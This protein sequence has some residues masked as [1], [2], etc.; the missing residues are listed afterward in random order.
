MRA[1]R[2]TSSST[3][4]ARTS[5]L[6]LFCALGALV[7]APGPA[8]AAPPSPKPA[9]KTGSV[10]S[11]GATVVARLDATARRLRVR[12]CAAQPCE[13]TGDGTAIEF[14][15]PIDLDHSSIDAVEL[16]NGRKVLRVVAR[17]SSREGIAWEA[18]VGAQGT[19]AKVLWSSVTGFANEG[20]GARVL[21]EGKELY[22][23]RLRRELTICGQKETLL[24]PK[25]L[26]PA[27]LE[28]HRV[29]MHRLPQAVRNAAPSLLA[30]ESIEAPFAN[31]AT[32]RGA[33][34]HDGAAPLLVDDDTATAWTETLKG[35]GKGE[36]VVVSTPKST[37]IEKL[38]LVVAPTKKIDGFAQPTSLWLS[39][40]DAT[41]HVAVPPGSSRVDVNLP[42]PISTSCLAL[43]LDRAEQGGA[44]V[45]VGLAELD[46]VPVLPKSIHGLD[47]LVSYLDLDVKQAELAQAILANAGARGA[48]AVE[49]KIATLGDR[50]RLRAI[51]VL[52]AAPC[53]VAGRAIVRLSWDSP[54]QIAKRAREA[55]DGC[56]VGAK[57]AIAE[58]FAKGPDAARE[59]IAE[60]FAKVDPQAALAA[61]L[62]VVRT[63]PATRRRTYRAAMRKVATMT[64]GRDAIAAYLASAATVAPAKNER[65]PV[66]EL[67]RAIA[68][69]PEIAETPGLVAALSKTLLSHAGESASFDARWL[70]AEPVAA[71]ALHGD[72]AA[73]AWLRALSASK[74]RYL[75]ARAISVSGDVD[76]LRPEV[77][78]ALADTEPRVRESAL[79]ALRRGQG[80]TGATPPTIALLELDLWTFVR[81]A[82]AETL[83]ESKGG[84]DVDV[85]LA[86]ATGDDARQVRGAAVR[87]LV[88]RGARSQLKAIR[89]R[90]FDKEESVDV[91]RDAIEGLGHLCDVGSVD[92]LTDI[93]KSAG[94]Q[95]ALAAIVALGDIHPGDLA[96]RLSA[97]DQTSLVV[98]DAVRRA[99][100]TQSQCGG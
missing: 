66:I 44:D 28:F 63:A 45:V 65:D 73:L 81:V 50:G 94:G 13:P 76:A 10:T 16:A 79:V 11:N 40:D 82:A 54:P 75:R 58:A 42:Q 91:R 51:D 92:A 20:E 68:D 78:R 59:A 5:R 72:V 12:A 1:E 29:A 41:F 17:S 56:G 64:V 61:L 98:K 7:T 96:S 22:V 97:I 23:G 52:E 39:T 35:D 6:L 95:L 24:E 80:P 84:G 62:D 34:V 25:R 99:M 93:A 8:L 30:V 87:A 67:A 69:L 100:K 89:A 19:D 14:A 46:A 38:T 57:G 48:Q 83:A 43:S 26:D 71:L 70:A 47:D 37:P 74:D 60:R 9:E 27:K 90:A 36:F 3:G 49:A 18:I 55:L 85:A 86:K 21:V 32:V 53:D 33:S 15:D 2:G 77:V 31:V 4:S 88:S